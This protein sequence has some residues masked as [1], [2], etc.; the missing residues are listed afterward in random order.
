MSFI[1]PR[2]IIKIH[3]MVDNELF[4]C[5]WK[6]QQLFMSHAHGVS[7]L[8]SLGNIEVFL[9][10]SSPRCSMQTLSKPMPPPPCGGH[11]YRKESMKERIV[12]RSM[13]CTLAR[14]IRKLGSWILLSRV[15]VLVYNSFTRPCKIF[16]P[17]SG[18]KLTGRFRHCASSSCIHHDGQVLREI[19]SMATV[20]WL[21]L[22]GRE[23][24]PTLWGVPSVVMFCYVF[25]LKFW[26][27]IG[28]HSSWCIN[29]MI[30]GSFRN[31]F[32]IYSDWPYATQCKSLWCMC[33]WWTRACML[34]LLSYN[35]GTRVVHSHEMTSNNLQGIDGCNVCDY[36]YD[37]ILGLR[38]RTF[39]YCA[40][41]WA[42]K[43]TP[44]RNSMRDKAFSSHWIA[45]GEC[46]ECFFWYCAGSF[47]SQPYAKTVQP[48]K[49]SLW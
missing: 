32:A 40:A 5:L 14:S 30:C 6:I 8:G 15:Y 2:M 9:I 41:T 17:T 34:P 33:I 7:L 21:G 44:S 18:G 1:K 16:W 11:P 42:R 39:W 28:L 45:L 23:G 43:G 13:P 49:C 4:W 20:L 46:R 10:L 24:L 37:S 3:Y 48:Q 35:F 47:F 29:P 31:C 36:V 26:L 38:E 12:S 22:G 19:P 25:S 27:P